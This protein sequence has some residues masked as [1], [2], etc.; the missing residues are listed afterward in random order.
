MEE[1]YT[2][3]NYIGGVY[4]QIDYEKNNESP[5]YTPSDKTEYDL[6]QNCDEFYEVDDADLNLML[7]GY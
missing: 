7:K 4:I 1:G 3:D 2:I 5:D 6:P